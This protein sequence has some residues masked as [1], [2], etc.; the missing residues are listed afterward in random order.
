MK[1]IFMELLIF[2]LHVF[3]LLSIFLF[4]SQCLFLFEFLFLFDGFYYY[5][6]GKVLHVFF[7]GVCISIYY[8]LILLFWF[9]SI[10]DER[11]PHVEFAVADFATKAS[12]LRF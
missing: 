6:L 12:W 5:F 3:K 7:L 10:F 11:A 8:K 1:Y 2:S 9:I 4:E